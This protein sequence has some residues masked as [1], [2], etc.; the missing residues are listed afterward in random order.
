MMNRSVK[1]MFSFLTRYLIAAIALNSA[2][3]L[4]SQTA[5]P[6]SGTISKTTTIVNDGS[7]GT[8]RHSK[9][10]YSSWIF[11]DGSGVQ[12]PFSGSD[13][14]ISGTCSGTSSS[15][16]NEWSND[17]FYYLSATGGQGSITA[18]GGP[19]KP[20]YKVVSILYATPGNA[21]SDSFTSGTTN[22]TTTTTGST[23]ATGEST[24]FTG[25]FAGTSASLQ[26][27]ASTT[28][29]NA[30]AFTETIA[31]ATSV[32]NA[33]AAAGPNVVSHNQDLIL[34]WLNPQVQLAQTSS[35]NIN[36]SLGTQANQV[37]DI[38]ELTALTMRDNGSGATSVSLPLL[39]RQFDS[40]TNA[41]DLAGLAA[42]CK[43]QSQYVNNCPSGGQ[44]GCV[45]SDFA[46]IL[47][48]DPLVN[49]ST[50][51]SPLAVDTSGAQTC[52]NPSA[53]NQCRYV[54]VPATTGGAVQA[55]ESLEGPQCNG[56]NRTVNGYTQTDSTSTSKTFSEATSTSVTFTYSVGFPL[57]SSFAKG[58]SWTWA[59]QESAGATNGSSNAI[60]YSL[61]SSTTYCS[62]EV[63]VFEDTVFHTFV[64]QLAPGNTSCP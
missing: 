34:V 22:G 15:S 29:G 31:N 60:G 16:L 53:G 3:S 1:N 21:S 27:G 23:F 62:T 55:D 9:A 25:G 30:T 59:D 40:A 44:C 51:T 41:Y 4:L 58:N 20:L 26:F 57:I 18:Q 61:S 52:S 12:H 37:P 14:T 19:I 8:G 17:G 46:G 38:L 35:S 45:P 47:A 6:P 36:F 2:S 10:T 49:T 7:C 28:M 54:P 56:C 64:T 24:T 33:S 50:A 43:D 32:S 39:Q 11:T 48:T 13:F 63:L 42:V 5:W